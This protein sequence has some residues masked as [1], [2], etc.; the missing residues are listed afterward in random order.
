[1]SID[2][3]RNH[4]V[5]QQIRPQQVTDSKVLEALSQVPR[6][7]FVPADYQALAF[8]ETFI[9][10]SHGQFMLTPALEGQ[11]L[12]ALS[13]KSTD[14]ILEVGTGSGYFTALLSKLGK[15]VYSVDCFEDLL[16]E[17]NEKFRQHHLYNI[18]LAHGKA[19]NGWPNH[20]PYDAMIFTGAMPALP[21]N[22]H[23]QLNIGGRLL[24][25]I[26]TEK[27]MRAVLIQKIAQNKTQEKILFETQIPKL[28][29]IKEPRVF[30]F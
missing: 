18:T 29:D 23:E 11:F 28:L 13:I 14:K 20:A 21:K 1:M 30:N 3:S 12:Q 17:A 10:L 4:M 7:D 27:L 2:A 6:E 22:I 25:V 16:E 15:H 8:A 26:G 5:Q 24:A 9:P 19:E